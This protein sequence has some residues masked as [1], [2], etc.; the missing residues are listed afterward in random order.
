M[1]QGVGEQEEFSHDSDDGQLSWLSCLY[2]ALVDACEVGI[3]AEGDERWHEQ[4]VAQPGASAS[5]AGVAG[6]GPRLSGERGESGETGGL[7]GF[8][9][10]KFV[11]IDEKDRGGRLAD[12]GD[13]AEDGEAPGERRVLGDPPQDFPI[14]GF[15]LCFDLPQPSCGLAPEEVERVV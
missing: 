7:L 1:E 4:G 10:T 13:A 2:E 5:N 9:R 14:D 15:E 8:Q 11:H 3:E 6:P 12:A